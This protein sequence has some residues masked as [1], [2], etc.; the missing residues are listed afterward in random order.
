MKLFDS[1]VKRL[2]DILVSAVGLL[3]L[4]PFLLLIGLLI[5]LDSPGPSLFRCQRM[6]RNQRPFKMLKF[7]TMYECPQSY[8]GPPVT[9][10]N[11]ERITPIGHWLRD[12][13]INELPQ[14]WNVLIGQMSLVGPRPEDVNIAMQ[15]PEDVRREILSV[16]PGITSPASILYSN[17]EKLL[18]KS[19][20]M[21]QYLHEI[22]P[23]KIRLDRLYVRNHSFISDLDIIFWTLTIFIPR[24]GKVKIPEGL[25]FFGPI[26]RLTSRYINWFILD[27]LTSLAVVGL[28]GVIWRTQ[29]PLNWGLNNLVI[30]AVILAGIFSG[31]NAL[32]GLN[33]IYW[34]KATIYDAAGIILSGTAAT[35]LVVCLNLVE[36]KYNFFITPPLPV[37]MIVIIGLLSQVG[38]IT[39]RFRFRILTAFANFWMNMRSNPLRVGERV[40]IVGLGETFDT[41]VEQL[42]RGRYRHIFN[43]V[44]VVEDA[45]PALHRMMV[46]QC[47]VLGGTA[48]LPD[49]VAKHDIGVVIFTIT[50]I[51]PNIKARLCKFSESGSLRI[52]FMTES[53][54]ILSKQITQP[55]S[56]PSQLLWSENHLNYLVTHDNVT[57]L[58]NQFLFCEQLRHSLAYS[59]RHHTNTAVM[60]ISLN[61]STEGIQELG[62]EASSKLLRQIAE[63]LL[64][65]KRG[66]D[67]L[68]YL[69]HH[70]FGLILE[71]IHDDDSLFSIADRIQ[72]LITGTF[73]VENK[74]VEII[75]KISITADIHN[76]FQK[77]LSGEEMEYFINQARNI[78]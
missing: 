64:Q 73:V 27:L 57:G 41:V 48:D 10:E 55:I 53:T 54:D 77:G 49:L 56:M 11:D 42:R 4:A 61:G 35:I 38:F 44:G 63:R 19:K 70:E 52:A 29:T 50:E 37:V 74:E 21:E 34:S 40:L 65:Y 25:L 36:A 33:R 46:N 15:W 2:F 66:T 8:E 47:L 3:L 1:L 24:I 45:D 60:F 39:I 43:I 9:F 16:R 14:L 58:P 12:T 18:C 30:F 28:I 5:R 17:E 69:D 59:S 32:L 71:N 7:R 13:K 78:I 26:S 20:V 62:A 76:Y 23:D 22:L 72:K 68:A 51:D 67:T 31:V 75:P 6:G